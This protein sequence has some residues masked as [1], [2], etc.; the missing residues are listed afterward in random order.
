ML[1]LPAVQAAREA[2]RVLQCQNHL[3][4]FSLAALGHEQTN[5]WLPTG[6]WGYNWVGDPYRGFGRNQPGGFFYNCLPFMEQQDLHDLALGGAEGSPQWQQLSMQMV[7][8]P[9]SAACCPSRPRGAHPFQGNNYGQMNPIYGSI[10]STWFSGDYAA[11]A[12]TMLS[13]QWSSGPSS[14]ADAALWTPDSGNSHGFV[15]MSKSTGIV[16]SGARSK[17]PTS[18]TARRIPTSSARSALTPTAIPMALIGATT[19]RF[20]PATPTTETAGQGTTP[21]RRPFPFHRCRTLPAPITTGSSAAPTPTVSTWPLCDGSVKMITYT[22]DPMTH[23]YLGNRHNDQP[24]DGKK[25]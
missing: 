8:T 25:L 19:S 24:I 22:I 10:P 23:N 14:F 6:G 9:V 15:N 16:R 11:N 20:I 3:K 18:P 5:G 7:Q 2:A 13:V 17:W 4:Q 1:L 21:E 12:G